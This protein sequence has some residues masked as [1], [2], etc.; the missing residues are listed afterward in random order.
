MIQ[1]VKLGTSLITPLHNLTSM[2]KNNSEIVVFSIF[3]LRN[4]TNKLYFLIK[5]KIHDK[6]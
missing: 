5:K 4:I 3:F 1:S 6:K 2:N